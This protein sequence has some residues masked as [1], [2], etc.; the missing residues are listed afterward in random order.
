MDAPVDDDVMHVVLAL[1]QSTHHGDTEGQAQLL[2]SLDHRLRVQVIG[3]LIAM[4][5]AL[6]ECLADHHDTTYDDALA[7]FFAPEVTS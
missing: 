6:I 7:A 1:V 4:A 2:A 5:H 3:S